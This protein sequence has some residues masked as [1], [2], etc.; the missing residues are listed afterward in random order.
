MK[1]FVYG[2]YGAIISV[3]VL[4]TSAANA[5]AVGVVPT[6]MPPATDAA[7]L[8]ASTGVVPTSMPGSGASVL[9]ASQYQ[10][11]RTLKMGSTGEDV[12][13]LQKWLN[14]HGYQVSATG[15]G[16][17]GNETTTFGAQTAHAVVRLQEAHAAAVLA[18]AGLYKGTGVFGVMTRAFVNGK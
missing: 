6:S 10:F 5:G 17:P 11:T 18:P 16:S 3:I 12:R 13:E 8:G 1:H 15:A 14:A 7:V 4:G 2:I 9:G